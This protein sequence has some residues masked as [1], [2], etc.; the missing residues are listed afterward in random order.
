MK[1]TFTVAAA[2]VLAG[3]ASASDLHPRH[4]HDIFHAKARDVFKNETECG[5]TTIY[6]TYYGEPTLYFPPPPAPTTTSTYVA[7]TTPPVV[8]TPVPNYCST[9]GVYT[10]PAHTVTLTESTTVCVPSTT[11]VPAGT[12]PVGGVTT[13]V[14]TATTVTCPY[15]TVETSNGVTTSVVK[16][17][18]YVCPSAG[19]YTIAPTT[20][21]VEHPTTVTVPA[22]TT[23][24]PGTYT[25]PEVVTTVVDTSTVVYCPF[26]SIPTSSAPVVTTTEKPVPTTTAAPAPSYPAESPSEYPTEYPTESATPKPKPS[27][28]FGGAAGVPWGTTFTPYNPEDGNC[29][30]KERVDAEITALA[31][32]G[33]QIIRT[34]S[35]DCNTLEH[36]GAACEKHGIQMIVGIFIDAPGCSASDENIAEQISALKSWA[37]WEIVPLVVVGNEAVLNNYCTPTQLADLIN[38]CKTEF[39]GYTGLWTTA[40]TTNVWQQEES[41]AALCPCVDIVGANAHPFF[42]Y[43]TSASD[44]GEFVKGQLD[45]VGSLCGKDAY[46]METGWPSQGTSEG[47]GI[48]SSGEQ[49]IA[50]KSIIKNCGDKAILFSIHDDKWKPGSTAC[51]VCEQH[52]GI[53]GVL[54]L[55]I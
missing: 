13:V 53:S 16:T 24:V 9:T 28:G 27:G 45:I 42:N 40:E 11:S 41:V 49:A 10:F 39:S 8:P 12:H 4:G 7:P 47:V 46:V 35:T 5:C 2:A 20:V 22:I 26:E 44:A 38:H 48:A 55:S 29:M 3:T 18:E 21:T 36:V 31:N 6:S 17:T 1:S 19:T 15:P 54:G 30:T 32:A 43:E 51:G 50:V 37:K 52:W 34:Y 23:Y 33:M 14:T 25:Q